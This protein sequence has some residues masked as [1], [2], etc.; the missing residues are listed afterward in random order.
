MIPKLDTEMGISVYSTPFK[1]CGGKIRVESEDF[2][3]KEILSKKSLSG[4]SQDSGFAVYKLKK[5]NIDTFHALQDILKKYGLRLKAL[6]LKDASAITEQFVCSTGKSNSLSEIKE[7]KYSLSGIGFVKKPLSKK[8]MIGNHFRIKIRNASSEILHF[9]EY[10][11]ILNFFG[12]QRFGS[13]RPVTHL[14]GKAILQRNFEK[15]VEI[16]LSYTSEYDLPKNTEIRRKLSDKSNYSKIL[17]NIPPQMDLEKTVLKKMIQNNDSFAA[18]RALPLTIRRFFV[19]AYQSFLFNKTLSHAYENGENLFTPQAN[20]I[21]YNKNGLI[22]KYSNDYLQRLAIPFIG[23]SYYKK[24]RFNYYISKILNSEE[25]TAKDFFLK[26]MQEVSNEGGFRNS[27]IN[28]EQF[29]IENDTIS[30][31]ISRG[32]YATIILRE[33]MKPDDP[34][35]AGF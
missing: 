18:I 32:S 24:T 20:D 28:C 22:E 12:Y 30:F 9:N 2:F 26:E 11:K 17:R 8:Y 21:C 27:S 29:L 13:K 25:I 6:G 14:I 34:I 10:D 16:L 5:R 23:Y 1:G 31:Q 19:Q 7:N 15:A 33:I 35:L 3:V 4:I